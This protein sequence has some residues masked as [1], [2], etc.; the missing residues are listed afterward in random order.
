ME[1][2]KWKPLKKIIQESK[3]TKATGMGRLSFL[4]A[5]LFNQAQ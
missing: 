1:S 5:G 3:V 2:A 4:K